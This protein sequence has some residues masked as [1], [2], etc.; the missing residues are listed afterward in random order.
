MNT[1]TANN[2]LITQ[3]NDAKRYFD[4]GDMTTYKSLSQS[5]CSEFR[6]LLER[7]VEEDLIDKLVLRHRRSV[8]TD[9]RIHCLAKI[10]QDDCSYFDGLMSKYSQYMHSQSAETPVDFPSEPDLR[11]DIEG[12]K[13][14]REAFRQRTV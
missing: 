9:N 10:N 8:T 5:I 3:L 12:L 11:T 1:K 6:K 4:D 2:K 14:W 13:T 7:T